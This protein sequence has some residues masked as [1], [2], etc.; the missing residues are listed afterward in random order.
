MSWDG[1][2]VGSGC[3]G[4]DEVRVS[5]GWIAVV[6]PALAVPTKELRDFLDAAWGNL[7]RSAFVSFRL[8]LPA[9]RFPQAELVG[10]PVVVP[11]VI[12]VC[13][14]G[15][16]EL[17]LRLA[18]LLFLLPYAEYAVHLEGDHFFE[19][20]EGV[21]AV[22]QAFEGLF[23]EGGREDGGGWDVGAVAVD[24]V[25]GGYV[26]FATVLVEEVGVDALGG[27]SGC[28][29]TDD[30]FLVGRSVDVAGSGQG[31]LRERTY[32]LSIISRRVQWGIGRLSQV[33][34]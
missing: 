4:N 19:A 33:L 7:G 11:E 9:S 8:G 34:L 20:L 16:G 26:R 22:A 1:G 24:G 6:F 10:D 3:G 28:E 25:A 18:G 27:P 5:G 17:A 13:P 12:E 14:Q 32:V 30:F 23:D 31:E 15:E 29:E 2:S 21:D